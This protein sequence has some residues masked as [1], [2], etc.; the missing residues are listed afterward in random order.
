LPY[1]DIAVIRN[2]LDAHE[3]HDE[4]TGA[5]YMTYDH[6]QWVSFDTP[7]TLKA[8]VDYANSVGYVILPLSCE[9]LLCHAWK[10]P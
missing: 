9:G 1:K 7:E 3:V 2:Q 10:P 4:E 8:K 6:D 5:M